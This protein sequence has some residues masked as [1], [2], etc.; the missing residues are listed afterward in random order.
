MAVNI[1]TLKNKYPTKT[2]KELYMQ[3]GYYPVEWINTDAGLIVRYAV[4]CKEKGQRKHYPEQIKIAERD[5]NYPVKLLWASSLT[6]DAIKAAMGNLHDEK[7]EEFVNLLR[8]A[9]TRAVADQIY[10][11][12]Y[13]RALTCLFST[14]GAVLS[15]GRCQTP[16]LNLIYE[17]DKQI[18][19]F[20]AE[21]FWTISATFNNS[22]QAKEI[23]GSGEIK[24][25]LK[26]TDAKE[27]LQHCQGKQGL[28]KSCRKEAK[29]QKAPSLFNL[30]ELQGV[31]GKKY[32]LTPDQTLDIA[33]KLYETW[34]II[35]NCK[36]EIRI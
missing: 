3:Y 10:G 28:V 34:R 24:R 8:E 14:P 1:I 15:Y 5:I 2:E 4:C 13:T 22:L 35:K 11:Y 27:T 26:E 30:A 20:K 19:N 25:Y 33:Q 9:E 21:P 17:R 12:N 31:M 23:D 29:Q 32:G 7:E 16:L 6:D 18:E 36:L